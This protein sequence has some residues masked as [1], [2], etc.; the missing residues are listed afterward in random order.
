MIKKT[1]FK[2]NRL[3][4]KILPI[5]NKEIRTVEKLFSRKDVYNDLYLKYDDF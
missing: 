4:G 5:T 1:L 3:M 2:M